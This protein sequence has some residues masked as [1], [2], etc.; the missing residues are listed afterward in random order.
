MKR[1]KNITKS[2]RDEHLT[3]ELSQAEILL[4]QGN[5]EQAEKLLLDLRNKTQGGL[6]YNQVTHLLAFLAFEK[7]DTKLAYEYLLSI[8]D[9][10]SDEAICLMHNLAFEEN[11]YQMV[12]KLSANCYKLSPSKKVALINARTFAVLN[13][14]KPAGGWLKTAMQFEEFDI[15]SILREKYFETV[16]NDSSFKHFF[17]K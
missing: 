11:D 12:K 4:Q 8:K 10:L 13:E 15:K 14:P 17:N 5:K 1:T 7:K 2:D 9:K 6:I 3:K 16:K